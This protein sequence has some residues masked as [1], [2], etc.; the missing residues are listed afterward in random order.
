MQM[1][2]ARSLSGK[3]LSDGEESAVTSPAPS[4]WQL[5]PSRLP[6][7]PEFQGTLERHHLPL[8]PTSVKTAMATISLCFHLWQRPVTASSNIEA[9]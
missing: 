4:D 9:Q 8:G 1:L 5:G 6:E 2:Q 3:G 7:S